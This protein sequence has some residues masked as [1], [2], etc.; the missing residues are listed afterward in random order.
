M[1]PIILHVDMD[2]FF[3]SVEVRE[4]PALR[5]LPVVVGADPKAGTGRGVVSTASYEARA[6]GIRSGMAI[7]RAYHLCPHAIYLPVNFSLYREVSQHLMEILA[8]YADHLEQVS[9]DEAFLVITRTTTYDAAIIIARKI[10]EALR[11]KEKLNC[12]IGIGPSRTVAKIASDVQK[13]NGLTVVPPDQVEAFLLPLPV[14]RLPGIGRKTEE[15]LTALGI[16]TIGELA[17]VDIQDLM[18][19]FGK[20]GLSMYR[21][22]HGEDLG[23][24]S[25]E[26]IPQSM[27][28][29]ITFEEDTQDPILLKRTMEDLAGDLFESLTKGRYQFRTVTI[30][31]RDA[32]FFTVTRSCTLPHP[33]ADRNLLCQQALDL[34]FEFLNGRKIRLLGIRV[35][36]LTDPTVQETIQRYIG[37]PEG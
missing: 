21:L 7:S 20:W 30:K 29:E 1:L 28:R 31:V 17:R 23:P 11:T 2:S 3:A 32:D 6:C 4:N 5:S 27:S 22:A 9:I 24:F 14:G 19:R 8:S 36:H 35:S 34:L 33:A 12:S 15:E 26:A 18:Q 10:Q 37:S 16:T 25:S 13:P